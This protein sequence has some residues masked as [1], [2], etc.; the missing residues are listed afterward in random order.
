LGGRKALMSFLGFSS[1]DIRQMEQLGIR[2]EQVEE[3]MGLLSGAQPFSRLDR[4]CTPGDGITI[5]SQAEQKRYLDLF[6]AEV[7]NIA[8]SKFVPASGAAT[9][10]FKALL[11]KRSGMLSRDELVRDASA[12]DREAAE[13]LL[14]I[15]N[16]KEFAFFEDLKG[17]LAEEDLDIEDLIRSGRF[18]LI[19]D[20]MLST[21]G[22]GYGEL[23]KGLLPFHRYRGG[24]RT[25][26]E[27]HLVE[28]AHYALDR[29]KLC[30]LAMT[31]SPEHMARFKALEKRVV[32]I[33]EEM[34]GVRIVVDFSIQSSATDTIA[35]TP[36]NQPFRTEEGRLL[37][38]PAGHGALLA[39]LSELDC[40][41]AFITNIDNV[42]PD[43]LKGEVVRWKKILGG[44]LLSLRE[45]TFRYLCRLS[46]G[47]ADDGLLDSATRFASDVLHLPVRRLAPLTGP[48][49]ARGLIS[50]L[51][52]PIRVCG[53]VRNQGEPG[54]GPFWVK[55]E[56]GDAWLQI[57]EKAQVNLDSPDQRAAFDGSTHF[58]PVDIACCIKDRNGKRHD[59]SRFRDPRAV[60]ISKKSYKGR[61]LKAL[62]LPGLWNGAM[63]WW[64][65]VFVEVPS[66]TFNPVKT[67]ND[68][69]RPAHK[70]S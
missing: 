54:G 46:E 8:G 30:R 53:M 21:P 18:D 6:E 63:A 40:D 19:I 13:V 28:A 4:P 45:E 7:G 37:F 20:R 64:I 42:V 44:L 25:A 57:V 12:G 36:D 48:D 47:I 23:P 10:M 67:V 35:V 17:S 52:R 27:E 24:P 69:L 55:D 34:L 38:R 2:P 26:F 43:R 14:F 11:S 60:F 29:Q 5:L 56:S 33:Y 32:K 22:L 59:L 62:E 50:L 65:T 61:E 31:V 70:N 66:E 1:D 16:I 49:L 68:L 3:Q 39:N 15:D 41:A 58:N 9:R 51:D